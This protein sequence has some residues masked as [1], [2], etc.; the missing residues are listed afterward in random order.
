MGASKQE[1]E[2]VVRLRFRS[3]VGQIWVAMKRIMLVVRESGC[4]LG[5]EIWVDLALSEALRNAVEHG[6]RM[7][8]DKWVHVRCSC[9][10]EDGVSIVVRDE[11]P[12]FDPNSVPDATMPRGTPSARVGGIFI[13]QSCMDE[14]S[15]EKGGTEVHLRMDGGRSLQSEPAS[16]PPPVFRLNTPGRFA[17]RRTP[18]VAES[19]EESPV[20]EN[21]HL[22]TAGH[23]WRAG[24]SG[25]GPED[26]TSRG[27]S[28]GRH[29]KLVVSS[30]LA[31]PGRQ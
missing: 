5:R 16:H 23:R 2:L 18:S 28:G 27:V 20:H 12:G 4:V 15:F 11:G 22:R 7:D 3:D 17:K 21:T 19:F 25:L 31:A 24:R 26:A 10:P 1:K 29:R 8:P 30:P 13:M 6:N 9:D 14:V